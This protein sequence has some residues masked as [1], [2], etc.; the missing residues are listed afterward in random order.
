MIGITV[1]QGSTTLADGTESGGQLVG[2]IEL[3]H[4][5]LVEVV[6][7]IEA[8][9]VAVFSR[10]NRRNELRFSIDKVFSTLLEAR[11][12]QLT[13]GDDCEEKADLVFEFTDGVTTLTA[14]IA[15]AGW[16][17]IDARYHGVSCE[18]SYSIKG[19]AF[20][21]STTSGAD[22]V[23]GGDANL[24]TFTGIIDGGF[25]ADRPHY[26]VDIL[27]GQP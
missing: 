7:F 6:E 11:Q 2:D 9:Q 13:A 21:I 1:K 19:G 4:R 20:T 12:A 18:V 26:F 22:I 14:T 16:E 24:S 15:G 3:N 5:R 27:D 25:E 8:L 10:G 17:A 23:D